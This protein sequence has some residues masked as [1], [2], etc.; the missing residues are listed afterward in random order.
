MIEIV[1]DKDLG[2]AVDTDTGEILHNFPI[3]HTVKKRPAQLI[4]QSDTI[5]RYSYSTPSTAIKLL[6]TAC[7]FVYKDNKVDK[8]WK[9]LQEITKLTDKQMKTA[10][11]YLVKHKDVVEVGK[12]IL[13]NPY[14]VWKGS[15]AV[16]DNAMAGWELGKYVPI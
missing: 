4:I 3:S 8:S 13:I 9:Y 11:S 16:R 15:T 1:T 10:K 14:Y 7:H 6:N 5:L 2:Y 12:E